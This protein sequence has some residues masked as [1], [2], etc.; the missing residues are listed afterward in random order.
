MVTITPSRPI[1]PVFAA[2]VTSNSVASHGI[3][4]HAPSG[5]RQ[6]LAIQHLVAVTNVGVV[7]T[8]MLNASGQN[9]DKVPS[10]VQTTQNQRAAVQHGI[11]TPHTV[12]VTVSPRSVTVLNNMVLRPVAL[13]NAAKQ[14]AMHKQG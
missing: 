14:L 6:D 3:F 2:P 4:Q 11:V 9:A 10:T 12:M 8:R 5:L 1:R 13:G 7:H